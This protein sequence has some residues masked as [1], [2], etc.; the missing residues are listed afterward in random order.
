MRKL[1]LQMH[2]SLDNYVNME[3]GGA[4]FKW[5]NEVIK[6]C[7]DNLDSVDTLLLG[8]N[9]AQELIPFW[10]DVATK[11]GHADFALGKRISELPKIVL[12]NTMTDPP[13]KNTTVIS[14]DLRTEVTGLKKMEGN[15][16]LVYGGASFASYLIQNG[17]VDEYYFLLNPFRLGKGVTIFK[18]ADDVQLFRLVQHKPFPCGTI[19]LHYT[20][21]QQ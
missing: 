3:G 9:T 12:S 21:A 13:W 19:M 8:R 15:D 16:I 2:L 7:V 18:P 4:H 11:P 5:D 20:P 1:K 6:F 14:G 17:L 10:D